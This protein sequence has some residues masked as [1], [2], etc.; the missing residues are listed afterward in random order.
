MAPIDIKL[1]VLDT[2]VSSAL[3]YA[4]ETWGTANVPSLEVAYRAGLK[5]ALSVRDSTSSEVVYI[6]ADRYP[7]SVRLSRQQ[8]NFWISLTTYLGENPEHPL[9]GLIEYGRSINLKYIRYYDHLLQ[10]FGNPQDCEK[11]LKQYL[12]NEWKMKIRQKA[13]N[14]E[15]S[16]CGAYL[17]V[18][19]QLYPPKQRQNIFE[20]ERIAISRYRSGSHSLRIETGRMSNPLV[21]REE[22]IC[23]CNTGIQT[24]HHVLFE[25]PLLAELH[26]EYAFTSIEQAFNDEEIAQFLMKMER[27]LG[28][29]MCRM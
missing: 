14:D 19:P 22:R 9:G 29:N 18:N 16:R 15:N 2:C 1:T 13:G 20:V 27:T 10:E 7:L 4:C 23:R 3:I 28:I 21:P 12:C 17:L 11:E 8:L 24:L 25:C 5:R 26:E 6:E